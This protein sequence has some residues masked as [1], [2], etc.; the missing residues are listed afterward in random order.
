MYEAGGQPVPDKVP[1]KWAGQ[2][3]F[4]Q[5][6]TGNT[7][8]SGLLW[9]VS[10]RGVVIEHQPQATRRG[11]GSHSQV[12]ESP[13]PQPINVF[14]PWNSVRTIELRREEQAE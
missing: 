6:N 12:E 13:S 7:P 4:V 5:T 8:V 3:V 2:Q 14:I 10:D 11:W 1:D 9:Q